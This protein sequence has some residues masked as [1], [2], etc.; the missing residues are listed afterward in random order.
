ML[1]ISVF[2]TPLAA[3]AGTPNRVLAPRPIAPNNQATIHL[4]QGTITLG[5]PVPIQTNST[6]SQP[7]HKPLKEISNSTSKSSK[8]HV[9]RGRWT[10]EEDDKLKKIVSNLPHKDWQAVSAEFP[11]RS[12]VQ[13]QQRW[14]KV[15]NPNLIKGPW[16]KEVSCH[17]ILL[18]RSWRATIVHPYL[19]N[20]QLF[21]SLINDFLFTSLFLSQP[22]KWQQYRSLAHF[23]RMIK[24][25]N[26]LTSMVPKS[27][28]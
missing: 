19:P 6:T 21:I 16:T 20:H 7:G 17:F 27:G 2:S 18:P 9:N 26:L 3:N 25:L 28:L 5:G 12:D 8:K 14:E 4:S 22:I 10:K 24:S 13:C 11:D 1:P 23:R 15:V